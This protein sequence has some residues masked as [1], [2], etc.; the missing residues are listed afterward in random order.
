MEIFN[1]W[2]QLAEL[3]EVKVSLVFYGLGERQSKSKLDRFFIF[4]EWLH[5]LNNF[6]AKGLF[7]VLSDHIPIM[8]G[9]TNHKKT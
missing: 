8:L 6:S 5:K 3:I 2:I 7:K 9:T 1:E 4:V